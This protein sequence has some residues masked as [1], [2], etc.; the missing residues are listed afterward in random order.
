MIASPNNPPSRPDHYAWSFG[1]YLDGVSLVQFR[2]ALRLGQELATNCF[3]VSFE[4]IG[5]AEL[6]PA[7]VQVLSC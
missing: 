5:R 4:K 2:P 1:F 3:R 6:C 7:A